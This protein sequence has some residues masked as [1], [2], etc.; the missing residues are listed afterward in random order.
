MQSVFLLPSLPCVPNINL[1]DIG[2]LEGAH[3]LRDG[4][5]KI[6]NLLLEFLGLC[7][8]L[9]QLLQDIIHVLILIIILYCILSYVLILR[10]WDSDNVGVSTD[11]RNDI[12]WNNSISI[13]LYT[14][15]MYA[16]F[17]TITGTLSIFSY[18]K[19]I[20]LSS[21]CMLFVRCI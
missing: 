1:W 16:G 14:S 10:G 4:G 9:L 2:R 7:I 19:L 11:K 12:S 3:V 21:L 15:S 18:C 6:H 5:Q 8:T 13:R 17:L 20:L